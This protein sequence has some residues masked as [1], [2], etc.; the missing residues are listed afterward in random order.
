MTALRRLGAMGTALSISS[1]SV[2]AQQ[3]V[4]TAFVPRVRSAPAYASGRGPVVMIDE[5]HHNFHTA[6]GRYQPFARLLGAD[7]FVIRSNAARFD[8]SSLA[9]ARVLVIANAVAEKNQAA[10]DWRL[11]VASAFERGEV[12]AVTAWVERGGSLLLIADHLPFA[13]A[14]DSLASAFGVYF[15]NGFAIPPVGPDSRTGDYPIVFRKGDG[16]LARHAV[17]M[18]RSAAERIDSI[19]SFT[20][21]A[22][23]LGRKPVDQVALMRL[24]PETGVKLPLVA[25]QFSDSTPEIRGDD[26]LQG[27]LLRVGRGRVAVFGEAAMFSAQRKGPAR[28]PMGM[29]A[30]E[31]VQNAQFILN[32][33]HWLAGKLDGPPPR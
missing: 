17:T 9:A 8:S 21:S 14:A 10:A 31:A 7:G 19:V 30:P 16:S 28:V 27:A 22:F 23:R 24:P 26:L 25:W 15:V 3:I 4:D 2:L 13:G 5:A 33:L 1:G 18:G 20:G 12:A 29:N 6:T 32:T 11:P